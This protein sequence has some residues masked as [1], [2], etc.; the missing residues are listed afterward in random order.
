M[1]Q[2]SQSCSFQLRIQH[3]TTTVYVI[4]RRTDKDC[5]SW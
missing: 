3:T 1:H 5:L 4:E 2:R